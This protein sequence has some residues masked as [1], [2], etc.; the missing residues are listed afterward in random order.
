MTE[1]SQLPVKQEEYTPDQ[2]AKLN[3][4]VQEVQKL[5]DPFRRE[6]VLCHHRIGEAVKDLFED[7][8]ESVYGKHVVKRLAEKIGM[9]H[10][11]LYACREVALAYTKEEIERL[12]NTPNVTYTHLREAA[13]I[14]DKELRE[15]TVLSL[16]EKP[17][18]SKEFREEVQEQVSSQGESSGGGSEG[19][20]GTRGASP[21]TPLRKAAKAVEKS[22]S[23]LKDALEVVCG[24]DPQSE[25]ALDRLNDEINESL[26]PIADALVVAAGFVEKAEGNL[27]VN[28][29]KARGEASEE[30]AVVYREV[31]SLLQKLCGGISGRPKTLDEVVKDAA[32]IPEAPKKGRKK[33]G[34]PPPPPATPPQPVD[35]SDEPEDEKVRLRE[36]MKEKARLAREKS[37]QAQTP[38]GLFD[39]VNPEDG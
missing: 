15:Q 2:E 29:N 20:K 23:L 16:A 34:E 17:L 18:T 24:F 12:A 33:K 26:G 30:R 8:A 13:A 3:E 32:P 25:Q 35:K 28:P 14:E 1:D 4:K 37:A 22:A 6:G 36:E 19:S 11:T 38:K 39:D 9:K 10:Q 7:S 31:S 5:A 27:I 21:L